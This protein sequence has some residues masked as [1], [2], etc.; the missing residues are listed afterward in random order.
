MQSTLQPSVKSRVEA[1]HKAFYEGLEKIDQ[2]IEATNKTIA[3]KN[4]EMKFV[5][6]KEYPK[7]VELR[8]ISGDDK[9]AKKLKTLLDKLQE[10]VAELQ[11]ELVVIAS[12]RDR[13]VSTKSAEA[14]E[15][16]HDFNAER[17]SAA[18]QSY[19]RM[20]VAKRKYLEAL[21][22]ES[23]PLNEY[24]RVDRMLEGVL[25]EGGHTKPMSYFPNLSAKKF[26]DKFL[27]DGIYLPVT[28]GEA[29]L[30]IQGRDTAEDIEYLPKK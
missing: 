11:E 5:R 26:G 23:K 2:Q 13:Y 14:K 19:H 29:T 7:A 3:D 22:E 21:K 18:K 15:L 16:I 28:Y 6:E 17:D 30:F 9:E 12:V 27:T 10:D 8:V 1:F 4:L 24:Y 20:S 25:G